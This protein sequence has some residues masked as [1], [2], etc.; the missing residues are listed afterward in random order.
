MKWV[1][2]SLLLANL[3]YMAL[4]LWSE[5]VTSVGMTQNADNSSVKNSSSWRSGVEQ[6]D[7]RILFLSEASRPGDKPAL[8]AVME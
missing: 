8:E 4:G 5:G 7:T 2:Y 3:A 6:K 1:F